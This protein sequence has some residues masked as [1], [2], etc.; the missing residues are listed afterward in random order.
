M[1]RAISGYRQP[2]TPSQNAFR[3]PPTTE[4]HEQTRKALEAP[5]KIPVHRE[6]VCKRIKRSDRC[7]SADGASSLRDA[8]QG[9][10]CQP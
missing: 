5:E 6:E 10:S 3:N 4:P 7:D 8:P 1:N 2:V 9:A